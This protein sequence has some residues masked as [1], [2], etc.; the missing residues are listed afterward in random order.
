[1][2]NPLT[3]NRQLTVKVNGLSNSKMKIDL[4]DMTGHLILSKENNGNDAIFT[5]DNTVAPGIYLLIIK[6]QN[7]IIYRKLIIP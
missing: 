4:F 1:M 2:P 7:S 3:E 6:M 5:I